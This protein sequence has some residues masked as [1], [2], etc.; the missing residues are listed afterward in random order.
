MSESNLFNP[1]NTQKK[2]D[3]DLRENE[4]SQTHNL[5]LL[6]FP[7]DFFDKMT[8]INTTTITPAAINANNS[9]SSGPGPGGP[10]KL[11]SSNGA[12]EYPLL[13]ESHL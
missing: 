3:W 11:S 1:S 4:S 12:S 10:A 9:G 5:N 7:L 8:R 2:E 6:L 13:R